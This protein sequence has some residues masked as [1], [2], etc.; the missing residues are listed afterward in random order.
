M[1][2]DISNI[3]RVLD[4]HTN[5]DIIYRKHKIMEVFN[6]DPDI[7]YI[8][9]RKQKLPLNR[10]ADEKNPTEA[11]LKE[12]ERIVTYNKAADK[13][14]I[15]PWLKIN[16]IQKE[17]Q[18]FIM[19]DIQDSRQSYTNEIIKHQILEVICL[20][21]EDDMETEFEDVTR[22]D[23]LSYLV[24]DLINWSNFAGLHF[25][26]QSN[27]PQITDTHYYGRILKFLVKGTNTNNFRSGRIANSYE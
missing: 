19:F 2:R 1:Q 21:H 27:T 10:Y 15:L 26:L 14:Q 11:E 12:R 23:L 24:V 25:E 5:N 7:K 17:V 20:V 3:Q 13:S 18:N 22:A 9:N 16:E 6:A 4:K 8:L